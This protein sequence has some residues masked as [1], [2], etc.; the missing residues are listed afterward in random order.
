MQ[1]TKVYVEKYIQIVRLFYCAKIE[2]LEQKG[3]F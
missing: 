2:S 3:D 1:S